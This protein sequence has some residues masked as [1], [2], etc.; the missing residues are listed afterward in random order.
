MIPQSNP[1]AGF[2]IQRVAIESAMA[3]VLTSG[4]YILGEE[5]VRFES[6]FAQAVGTPWSVG[7]GSG[8]DAIEIAL[9][10]L[11]VGAGD[12]VL[13]VSHTAV[14]TAA[15]IRRTGALPVF[16]D[17]EADTYTMAPSSL[18]A[19]L[20]THASKTAKAI[21]VVHLYGQMADMPAL[22][23]IAARHG[24]PVIE[25]CA[26]AHG[27]SLSGR[28]AGT[29]GRMGCFSFYPT[30]NLGCFGDG[31]AIVGDDIRLQEQTRLI[32]EYGWRERYVSEIYGIN[33]RL[34]PLQ[35]AVLA[36]K[37]PQLSAQNEMRRHW[38]SH[39]DGLLAST[40]IGIP[41]R[42]KNAVHVFHQYVIQCE[43]R[44]ELQGWLRSHGVA[45]LVHYP[46]A[47]HQ[48]PAYC[49]RSGCPVP[50]TV[51]EAITGRI[52]SLPMFPEL[53]EEQ[54]TT[55]SRQILGWMSH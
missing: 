32:R 11:G 22:N 48:Q 37:L 45:T 19:A 10:A 40:R 54:V 12:S 7:V 39:Y 9:R 16:V 35:A 13:T 5:V 51:T 33:S 14:A 42:R 1:K 23:A 28:T 30:K 3:R 36:T 49:D 26:Q 27:A 18:E 21:I 38:A 2:E 29:W 20:A 6:A 34:D 41:T 15:A 52:L 25:D 44:D 43:R 46:R 24:L 47:V 55:V 4:W 17:I 50:L 31:G 8:T 53:T